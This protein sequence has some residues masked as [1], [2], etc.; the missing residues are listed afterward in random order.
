MTSVPIPTFV[1]QDAWYALTV[2]NINPNI[3]D[4]V[5]NV[6]YLSPSAGQNGLI[7]SLD[8]GLLYVAGT[9][10]ELDGGQDWY[11]WVA[12]STTPANGQSVFN[13]YIITG[14]PGR[15]ISA[16][17]PTVIGTR[18]EVTAGSSVSILPVLNPIVNIYVNKTVGSATTLI[19]PSAPVDQQEFRVFD[20]K[21]DAG[22]NP[23][24]LVS[25]STTVA[26]IVVNG[27]SARL[28]WDSEIA[29]WFA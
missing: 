7:G 13:P 9:S 28:V 25:G 26:V 15:W 21:G 4:S 18:Q 24:T 5:P 11:M 6:S 8:G 20:A 2:G 3:A 14:T 22:T 27:G 23:I 29:A 16:T 10:S 19:M 1:P 12:A 17:V